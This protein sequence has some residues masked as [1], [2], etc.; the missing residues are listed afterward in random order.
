M[1][2]S[3]VA[4]LALLAI[5]PGCGRRH[6]LLSVVDPAL[7]TDAAISRTEP[8]LTVYALDRAYP[9]PLSAPSNREIFIEIPARTRVH[10][11]WSMPPDSAFA[12]FEYR[13]ALDPN[14]PGRGRRSGNGREDPPGL[15]PHASGGWSSDAI[16]ISI[17]P[18]MGGETHV[19]AIDVRGRRGYHSGV[20]VRIQVVQS[21]FK[22]DLLVV[23]DTRYPGDELGIGGC[24]KAP[25]GP[26]PTMAEL[27]TFLFAR[28]GT[29]WR[30]YPPGAATPAITPPGL[31][32][33]YSFD[34]IGTR[35][36]VADPPIPLVMLNQYRH[37]IWLTDA[38]AARN[39]RPPGDAYAPITALRWMSGP[40]QENTLAEYARGGGQV[41]LIGAG[42][43][44]AT[45]L[46]WDDQGPGPSTWSSDTGD[47]IPGRFVYDIVHWRSEVQSRQ[48]TGFVQRELGRNPS[49]PG[50][51]DYTRL[52][53]TLRGKSS[54]LDPLPPGR[55]GQ[56]SGVLYKSEF[57]FEYLTQPNA[58]VEDLDPSHHGH[59]VQ[60]VL[61]SVY[62]LTTSGLP[63]SP[64]K[65]VLMTFYHGSENGPVVFSG[66]DVW[67][68]TWS[69]A[70]ALV[71]FV[72]Q[73]I[74]S[75]QKY[76][77]SEELAR[78]TP[79]RR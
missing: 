30:C 31:F 16:S 15:D 76:P 72:L 11:A 52:P 8:G 25:S 26:W 6:A 23:N 47:L 14:E 34:T 28:G 38:V 75:M 66:L 7:Q 45:L 2:R 50:A 43:A 4:V 56:S 44:S 74:W 62:K 36:R 20:T 19:L 10:F 68:F 18:F 55:I 13:W 48:L 29:P 9:P 70:Q 27:D 69:D 51:P 54:A 64:E 71:D 22:R 78:V 73:D 79:L 65:R 58:I 39:N 57:D 3:I 46:P 37:V 53:I 35:W 42:V 17:G 59:D 24:V 33:G 67:D 5:L 49:W 12:P 63:A 60:S 21:T 40:G 61:D 41:W 77:G 32:A 1:P